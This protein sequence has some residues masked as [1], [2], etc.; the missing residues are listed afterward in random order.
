MDETSQIAAITAERVDLPMRRP[1]ESAKRLTTAA[2]LVRVTARL[3][4]GVEGRGEAAPAGYVT[5]EEADSLQ[6]A[7]TAGT[8]DLVGLPIDRPQ[9]WQARLRAALPDH[10]T[11]RSAV[12]A[13][14]YDALA[15]RCGVPLWRWWGGATPTVIS[16]LSIPLLPPEN[17]AAIAR[18]AVAAGFQHLK[19]KVGSPTP[20]EDEARV[21]AI[22]EAVPGTP[23]RLDGNQAFTPNL[24]LTFVHGLVDAGVPVELLEQPVDRSDWDGLTTVTRRSPV[25]VIADEAVLTPADALRVAATGA[26]QGINL[27]LAKSGIVDALAIIAIA[28]AAR[29]R[30]MLGCMIES[31]WAIRT[32]VHLACGTGAFD[33]LDLDSHVLIGQEPPYSGFWQ[34]GGTIGVEERE[35]QGGLS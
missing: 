25:P 30:L 19:I 11:G 12:E 13:A 3:Q 2:E 28:R 18:E 33:Y 8:A 16:D 34:R 7:V 10:P 24:A 9:V 4:S 1:F 20:G 21:R 23:L 26:A 15:A 6:L 32:A 27:K 31:D 29:L 5:G 22:A 35:K 17:A 14:L